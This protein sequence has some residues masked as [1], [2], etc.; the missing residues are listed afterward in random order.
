MW[1][2]TLRYELLKKREVGKLE[3]SGH[4]DGGSEDGR[5][6]QEQNEEP[7]RHKFL[8]GN[9]EDFSV[10]GEESSPE[11][12]HLANADYLERRKNDGQIPF[13]PERYLVDQGFSDDGKSCSTPRKS[14]LDNRIP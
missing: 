11:L 1:R 9:A 3:S 8:T 5:Q 13:C 6:S 7:E 2:T 10:H 4:W 14:T 12:S